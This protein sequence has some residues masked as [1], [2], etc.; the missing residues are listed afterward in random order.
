MA[1]RKEKLLWEGMGSCIRKVTQYQ[2]AESEKKWS[3][4]MGERCRNWRGDL[5]T[6]RKTGP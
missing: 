2:A 4:L 1:G 5:R 3:K 6:K